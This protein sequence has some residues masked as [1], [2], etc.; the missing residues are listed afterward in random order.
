LLTS[1]RKDMQRFI[2]R[3]LADRHGHGLLPSSALSLAASLTEASILSALLGD[4]LVP[5]GRGD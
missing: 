1:L 2:W 4:V 3:Q 5:D